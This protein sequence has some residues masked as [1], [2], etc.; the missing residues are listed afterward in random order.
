MTKMPAQPTLEHAR[1][2]DK[3]LL[4]RVALTSPR[5]LQLAPHDHAPFL[6]QIP[7]PLPP[8]AVSGLLVHVMRK[9]VVH[10]QISPRVYQARGKGHP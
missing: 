9:P 6:E 7:P 3:Y 1:P 4:L 2:S 5:H 10:A 8:V